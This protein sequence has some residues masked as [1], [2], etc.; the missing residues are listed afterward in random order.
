MI[1]LNIVNGNQD[2]AAAI[3]YHVTHRQPF[4]IYHDK[5]HY[6]RV[7]PYHLA[8]VGYDEH[9][10]HQFVCGSMDEFLDRLKL[11]TITN[12]HFKSCIPQLEKD[13]YRQP[14]KEVK[15]IDL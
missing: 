14:S 13:P 6:V 7:S 4:I 10:E 1:E 9:G 8:L 2:Y 11:F 5:E 12:E 3:E 15:T